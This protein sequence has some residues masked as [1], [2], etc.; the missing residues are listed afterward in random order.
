MIEVETAVGII[1]FIQDRCYDPDMPDEPDDRSEEHQA[2]VDAVLERLHAWLHEKVPGATFKCP[3]CHTER[4][5]VQDPGEIPIRG[6]FL[7]GKA[8][9]SV[10]F[11]CENCGYTML[12]NAVV[13]GVPDASEWAA[14]RAK[15]RAAQEQPIPGEAG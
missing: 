15:E 13:M 2:Y 11:I 6:P 12:F 14:E 4:W 7:P 8:Y 3:V 10:V 5:S 1:P 9:P